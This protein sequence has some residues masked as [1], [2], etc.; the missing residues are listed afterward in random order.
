MSILF[1]FY[2]FFKFSTFNMTMYGWYL[3][4]GQT[5][6]TLNKAHNQYLRSYIPIYMLF[7]QMCHSRNR[8]CFWNGMICH[9]LL[10]W[11]VVL[12]LWFQ[13]KIWSCIIEGQGFKLKSLLNKNI[14]I[15]FF[16]K[17][18]AKSVW[19]SLGSHRFLLKWFRS[20]YLAKKQ[21]WP[22]LFTF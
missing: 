15:P 9:K 16:F 8:N 17:S 10:S 2:F 11:L 18:F 20:W 1:L 4:S 14:L 21:M 19:G 6:L 7:V 3:H 13:I 22:H 5:H 12:K